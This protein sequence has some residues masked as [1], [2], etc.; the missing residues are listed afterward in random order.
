M[1]RLSI[2]ITGL[3]LLT[4]LA[5]ALLLASI[6]ARADNDTTDRHEIPRFVLEHTEIAA[7]VE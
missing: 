6:H 3:A 1:D 5:F 4:A 2:R 7:G